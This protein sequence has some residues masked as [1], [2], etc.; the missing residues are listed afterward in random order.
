MDD[1]K[2]LLLEKWANSNTKYKIPPYITH[3]LLGDKEFMVEAL[4]TSAYANAL[5]EHVSPELRKD[6]DIVLAAINRNANNISFMDESF[7][8]DRDVV[9]AIADNLHSLGSA[10]ISSPSGK[11]YYTIFEK[12]PSS[13]LDDREVVLKMV[14]SY[15]L[16]IKYAS[17]R[18]KRDREIGLIAS[19]SDAEEDV[20]RYPLPIITVYPYYYLSDE[21]KNDRQIALNA[22]SHKWLAYSFLPKQLQLDEEIFKTTFTN[23]LEDR[24]SWVLG[25]SIE[26]IF[27]KIFPIEIRNNR[28]LMLYVLSIRPDFYSRLSKELKADPD[29][30]LLIDEEQYKNKKTS[31]FS[32]AS[33]SI[34]ANKKI[35]EKVLRRNITNGPAYSSVKIYRI[36]GKM[37]C[38][39]FYSGMHEYNAANLSHAIAAMPG[40]SNDQ[41]RQELKEKTK[42]NPPKL[43]PD[44]IM[45]F[46]L[47]DEEVDKIIKEHGISYFSDDLAMDRDFV[48]KAIALR[49][50][51]Y[52]VAGYKF[53]LDKEVV[54]AAIKGGYIDAYYTLNNELKK[55]LDIVKAAIAVNEGIKAFVP[56]E[57]LEKLS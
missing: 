38:Y 19:D 57:V 16:A 47:S 54:L 8:Q 4:R 42:N 20:Y 35:A 24:N 34:I 39:F 9:L 7:Y 51:S 36:D 52:S 55:D 48:L 10:P 32:H 3:E 33:Y 46:E 45:D 11:L 2:T 21:L 27:D 18:L 23:G 37:I 25:K 43:Y 26:F 12:V 22:I 15:G 1:N 49:P 30:F 31:L 56:K 40:M 5:L 41:E 13:F 53:R 50:A 6:K 14:A 44:V 29:I 17:D 28:N